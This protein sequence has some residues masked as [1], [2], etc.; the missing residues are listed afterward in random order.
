M[1]FADPAV[2]EEEVTKDT[3]VQNAF[4]EEHDNKTEETVQ[5]L[6]LEINNMYNALESKFL[7]LWSNASKN[8]SDL[9][10]K[11]KLDERKEQLL[12]QLNSARES[13]KNNNTLNVTENLASIEEQ[14][15]KVQLPAVK[16]DIK[17]LLEQANTA[18]DVLDSKLEI[19]E[20]QAG[21]YVS[22]FA[23]FLS[24]MIS[25]TPE[26][27]VNEKETLFASSSGINTHE[28]Y[29]T[30]RYETDFYK[31][32]TTESYYLTEE[33]DDK[34]EAEKYSADSKTKEI[35]E[36]LEQYPQTLTK[37]MNEIV[38]VKVSYNLFWYRYFKNEDKLKES[39]KKRKELLEKKGS[40]ASAND[41]DEEF[42]WDDDEEDEETVNLSKNLKESEDE[43]TK[44]AKE[45]PK[46]EEDDDWE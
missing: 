15:K 44:P 5:K 30:S 36:L 20:N 24:N 4:S 12:G 25:V 22:S 18:L 31:L 14:I 13:L 32:H 29:G 16:V 42:T 35:S 43:A 40:Q 17:N 21:K 10:A 34:A 9:Q 37:L 3:S 27:P 26:A 33:L 2:A 8:A 19:V 7:D 38:P 23:S 28:N 39:E 1:E 45:D 6:E 41:D 46:D 11:Y